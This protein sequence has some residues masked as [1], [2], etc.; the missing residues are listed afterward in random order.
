MCREPRWS[1][2]FIKFRDAHVLGQ[3]V[4]R[5]RLE[6]SLVS[7]RL[8]WDEGPLAYS[9]RNLKAF[10]FKLVVHL[11]RCKVDIRSKHAALTHGLAVRLGHA[12]I[13]VRHWW[14]LAVHQG[15]SC[16]VDVLR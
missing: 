3:L 2:N 5:H 6:A 4:E 12:L 9:V 15:T 13:G 8:R 1:V 7:Y 16:S 14:Q 11:E 10:I